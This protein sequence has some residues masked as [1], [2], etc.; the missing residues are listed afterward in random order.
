[1][2]R[3]WRW[4]KI[5]ARNRWRLKGRRWIWKEAIGGEDGIRDETGL[6]GKG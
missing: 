5:E 4:Q 1:M 2:A 3:G 6:D